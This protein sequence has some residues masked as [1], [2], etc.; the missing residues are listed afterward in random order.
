MKLM[1]LIIQSKNPT[2]SVSGGGADQGPGL[3]EFYARAENLKNAPESPPSAARRVGQFWY[4]RSYGTGV[5]GHPGI[6]P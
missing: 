3:P 2:D 4:N 5:D 6:I 1:C